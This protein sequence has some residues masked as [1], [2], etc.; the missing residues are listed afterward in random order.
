MAFG[1]SQKSTGKS[2]KAGG[3]GGGGGGEDSN[4]FGLSSV[5]SFEILLKLKNKFLHLLC[6]SHHM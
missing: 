3:G 5:F 6:C 1:G 4:I 2:S